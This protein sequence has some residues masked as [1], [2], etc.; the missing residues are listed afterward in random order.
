MDFLLTVI[1]ENFT[2]PPTLLVSVE[3]DLLREAHS[4]VTNR[5]VLVHDMLEDSS[6]DFHTLHVYEREFFTLHAGLQF[7]T[8]VVLTGIIRGY[9]V[10]T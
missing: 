1:D 2:L 10:Q 7:E 6:V 3:D 5:D 8:D 4:S 9:I